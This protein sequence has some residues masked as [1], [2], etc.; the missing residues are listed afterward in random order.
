M[1]AF[2]VIGT[3]KACIFVG[4][5]LFLAY[6]GHRTIPHAIR[7]IRSPP[8]VMDSWYNKHPN[9]ALAS[10]QQI[11]DNLWF[12]LRCFIVYRVCY[13]GN[14]FWTKEKLGSNSSCHGNVLYTYINAAR[15]SSL[16]HVA[17][18]KGVSSPHRGREGMQLQACAVD[19]QKLYE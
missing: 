5:P 8:T 4:W 7:I 2:R 15:Q 3:N 9:T 10:P 18:V 13:H 14:P 6:C 12:C 16:T 1:V 19:H 11:I 17:I